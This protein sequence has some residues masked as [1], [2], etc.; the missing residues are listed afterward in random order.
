M[1]TTEELL[2]LK[3]DELP[4]SD[5]LKMILVDQKIACFG[6]VLN[7]P[8]KVWMEWEGFDFHCLKQI[9]DF[10][11]KKGLINYLRH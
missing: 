5:G 3:I 9:I 10:I 6:D 11:K 4:F 1:L 8:I 2:K 7:L